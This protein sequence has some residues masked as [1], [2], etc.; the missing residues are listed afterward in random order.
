MI[1]AHLTCTRVR[2]T[3]ESDEPVEEHGWVDSRW[4]MTEPYESRNYVAPVIGPIAVDDEDLEDEV[5][6]ALT[7]L[8]GGY[9][10]NGD[11][12]FYSA[13]SECPYLNNPEGWYYNYA[14]HFTNKTYGALGW[15]ETPWHPVRD[16]HITL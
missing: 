15:V 10:D 6:D 16:G 11:G 14:L 5:R 8:P 4:S 3:D 1:F 7:L 2:W 12:S 9:E 13:D